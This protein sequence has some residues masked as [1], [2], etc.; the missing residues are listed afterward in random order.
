MFPVLLYNIAMTNKRQ[1]NDLYLVYSIKHLLA[2]MLKLNSGTLVIYNQNADKR[3]NGLFF[4]NGVEEINIL[5]DQL[6][7]NQMYNTYLCVKCIVL[8]FILNI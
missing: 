8:T 1:N 3:Y 6:V 7:C 5:C 2:Y 4:G